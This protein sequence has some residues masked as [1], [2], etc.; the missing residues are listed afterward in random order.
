MVSFVVVGV[1]TRN[2][3][4]SVCVCGACTIDNGTNRAVEITFDYMS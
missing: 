4:L 3:A 2:C 1:E